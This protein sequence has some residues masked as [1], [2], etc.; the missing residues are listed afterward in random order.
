MA[1]GFLQRVRNIGVVFRTKFMRKDGKK[2]LRDVNQVAKE[3]ME[4]E[5][6]PT[7]KEGLAER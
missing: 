1:T 3:K 5:K 2:D 4:R 7:S 6:S